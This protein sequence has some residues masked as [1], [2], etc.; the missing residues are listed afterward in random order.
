M[1]WIVD[2]SLTWIQRLCI[3]ILKTG[4]VPKH[5][6][7]IMDGNRR[8]AKKANV[9]KLEGHSKGFDKL[10]ETLHWCKELGINE[11]TVYA[12]SIDNFKRSKEEVDGLMKLANEKFERLLEEK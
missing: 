5:V 10:A 3:N 11:V 9:E 1:S 6:A 8:Y 12:F 2:S 7:F 4:H